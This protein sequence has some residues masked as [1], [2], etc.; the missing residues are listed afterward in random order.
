MVEQWF[1]DNGDNTLRVNYPLLEDSIVFDLGGYKG[2]W[3]NKIYQKYKCNV[4]IFEPIPFL[5]DEINSKFSGIEKIKTYRF[6]LSNK[7]KKMDI[8]LSDDG[9]SFNTNYGSDKIECDV[10][11]IS[12]FIK[13][14]NIEK[15][16]LIKI[17]I[18]GDE[19]AVLNNLLD[20]KLINIFTNIQ[21][22][23]HHFIDNSDQKRK[24]IQDR[25]SETHELTYNYDFV[26]ENWEKR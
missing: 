16:D 3:A 13:D 21:V 7:T 6:G 2:E 10:V 24:L 14:N 17:N 9:S 26:W 1:R 5:V 23:F 4:F 20:N 18:E 25:L 15:I 22:Q 8:F 12:D 19:Y 11:S